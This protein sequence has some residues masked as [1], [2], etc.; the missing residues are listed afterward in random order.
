MKKLLFIPV[1]AALMLSC[2]EEASELSFSASFTPETVSAS[3][4]TVAVTARWS[5][6]RY[7]L[8]SDAEF[9]TLPDYRY[10]GAAGSSGE[11]TLNVEFSANNSE[12]ARTAD[13]TFVPVEGDGA[14]AFA[15]SVV[16]QG[17]GPIVAKVTVNPSETYQTWEGFGAMNLGANWG[18]HIDWTDSDVDAL[19]GSLG[20]NIMRIRIPYDESDWK[21]VLDGCKYAYN[22]YG[23]VILATPWT[24]PAYM[25]TP[26][27][28]EASKNDVTSSLNPSYYGEYA[29]YLEKFAAYMK[30]GGVPLH[31]VSVQNE[32]DWPATYEGCVWTAEEHLAFVRDYGHLV[33]SALLMTGESMSFKHSFYDPVLKDETALANIDIVGGH[34]Y[35]SKPQSYSLASANGKPLW[36]TEHLLNDSWTGGTSHW[37]ETMEMASE[38]HSCLVSGMN[39]YIW[40]YGKRYYS[41]IGDGNEGTASGAMLPRGRAYAQFSAH[42]RPGDIR[43]GVVMEG[44]DGVLASAFKGG[45]GRI[46]VV[47]VNT[48][49]HAVSGME[50]STGKAVASASVSCTDES[51]TRNLS[52]SIDSGAVSFDLP[53]SSVATVDIKN[54]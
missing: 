46:T 7:R 12:S 23:A 17:I 51:G 25:K 43:L 15:F 34:L 1:L 19:M 45:D 48:L 50:V 6:C 3:G 13:F 9:V 26:G 38:I 37:A 41:L 49:S 54:K 20:L 32:P 39:A 35:G 28:L 36:M 16:Q 21:T 2:A 47:I 5:N 24:M 30:S 11:N 14:E 33:K 29:Q 42:I 4:G 22:N 52:A 53:A 40:W 18:S 27:Q 44:T 10:V 31:A 8:S